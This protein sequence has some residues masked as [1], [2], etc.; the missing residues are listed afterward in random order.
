MD[1]DG[2]TLAGELRR[3]RV[4]RPAL[5]GA[6]AATAGTTW[7][8]GEWGKLHHVPSPQLVLAA[9]SLVNAPRRQASS[10]SY[11]SS[12]LSSKATSTAVATPVPTIGPAT[13]NVSTAIRAASIPR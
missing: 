8:P 4:G 6:L 10:A 3:R 9:L 13:R 11:R 12:V 7:L 5:R 2:N 1:V